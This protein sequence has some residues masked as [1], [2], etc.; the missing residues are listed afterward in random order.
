MQTIWYDGNGRVK[1]VYDGDTTSTVW[2]ERGYSK[3]VNDPEKNGRLSQ[4]HVVTV[5]NGEVV[6]AVLNPLPLTADQWFARIATERERHLNTS[7]P[8]TLSDGDYTIPVSDRSAAL[9]P[10]AARNARADGNT[11]PFPTDWGVVERGADDLDRIEEALDAYLTGVWRRVA[12]L[13]TMVSD[14]TITETDLETG[15]E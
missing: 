14:G 2:Q 6:D 8:V 10:A 15:W 1:A 13:E 5:E 4:D 9:A 11:R 12:Q 7:I 3:A